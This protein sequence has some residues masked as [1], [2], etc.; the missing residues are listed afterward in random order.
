MPTNKEIAAFTEEQRLAWHE[1]W[2]EDERAVAHTSPGHRWGM[3]LAS[4]LKRILIMPEAKL[5]ANEQIRVLEFLAGIVDTVFDSEALAAIEP[6]CD[7]AMDIVRTAMGADTDRKRI[8]ES[9]DILTSWEV[10]WHLVRLNPSLLEAVRIC[11]RRGVPP[12]AH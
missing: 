11:Q 5:T 8:N 9:F 3:V 2:N 10:F 6:A 4:Y 12:I 7:T 1:S